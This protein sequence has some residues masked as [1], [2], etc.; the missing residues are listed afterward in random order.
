M[1]KEKT[2]EIEQLFLTLIPKTATKWLNM[3]SFH[4]LN[5]QEDFIYP[6]S[7]KQLR[8]GTGKV[9]VKM[10][11]GPQ[12]VVIHDTGMP[13]KEHNAKGLSIYIHHQ[14]DHED[15]RVASWHFSCD[16]HIAYQHI[17]TDEIGWHAGDG[18][19]PFGS[20]YI[21]KGYQTECIGGGNQNGIGIETCINQGGNYNETLKNAAKLTAYLLNKYH[22]GLDRVK[23]HYHFSGKNCP[24]VIR[25]LDGRWESFLKDVEVELFLTQFAF[26]NG[27]WT[28]DHPEIILPGGGVKQPIQDTIAHITLE[29]EIEDYKHTFHYQTLVKGLSEKEQIERSYYYLYTKLIPKECRWDIILPTTLD[30]FGTTIE[31]V[32]SNPNVLTAEGRYHHPEEE[33]TVELEATIQANELK[34]R[35]KFKIIVK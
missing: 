5:I 8:P 21:N 6:D 22:L 31:W 15:G 20:T 7:V 34:N 29:L 17:P 18:S 27:K 28:T 32:S 35:F 1:N 33:T 3:V 30:P 19:A 9:G 13:G 16:E 23:Q 14:A 4:Q 2:K 26:V 24:N 25:S 11:G 12:Y 10:P